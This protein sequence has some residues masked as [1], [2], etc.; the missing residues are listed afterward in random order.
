[1]GLA[2]VL[3]LCL[4]CAASAATVN[5]YSTSWM[6]PGLPVQVC[7]GLIT[8]PRVQI[9]I[10]WYSPLSSALHPLALTPLKACLD[11]PEAWISPLM[12]TLSGRWVFPP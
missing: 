10:G 4:G 1:V 12:P 2:V 5:W 11:V 3:A 8:R 7:I 9:G 6:A